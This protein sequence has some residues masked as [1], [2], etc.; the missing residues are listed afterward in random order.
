MLSIMKR[1]IIFSFSAIV[2]TFL[3]ACSSWQTDPQTTVNPKSDMAHLIQ[4]VYVLVSWLALIVFVVIMFAIVYIS[5]KFRERPGVEARQFHGDTRLEIIWTLIPIL[6]VVTIFIPTANAIPKLKSDP[7]A[8]ALQID[9]VGKQWWFE[10][11]YPELNITTANEIHIPVNTPVAFNLES[12]DVIHAFWIPQL[13]GKVDMVPGHTNKMWFTPNQARKEAYLGQCTEFCGT[14]HANMLFRVFVDEQDDFNKWVAAQQ[15]VAA[16]AQS[17]LAKQGEA[18]LLNN[19]AFI[20]E[21]GSAVGCVTCHKIE[22]TTAMGVLA[23]NLTH[24]ASRSTIA[25]GVFE[26]NKDNLIKWI[27]NPSSMKP[28]VSERTG[29]M[30]KYE[31][32]LSAEQI[33]SIVA[34]LMELQ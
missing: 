6:I 34:Y 22:G 11:K 1:K 12:T 23:P 9:V 8:N 26:N 16:P 18:L 33:E 31:D 10:F 29:G 7:P 14:S 5:W 25:A 28:G 17:E 19:V 4:D 20:S 27:S 32:Y 15:S 21:N 24:I 3:T 30:P 2:G 13:G